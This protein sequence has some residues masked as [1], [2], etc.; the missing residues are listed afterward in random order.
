MGKYNLFLHKKQLYAAVIILIASITGC[1]TTVNKKL[2]HD[3]SISAVTSEGMEVYNGL[4]IKNEYQENGKNADSGSIIS[5]K[6]GMT[7]TIRNGY[8]DGGEIGNIEK[9]DY[10]DS[11]QGKKLNEVVLDRTTMSK[12]QITP[13]FDLF[14]KYRIK[15]G[16]L[17]DV[18]YQMRTWTRKDKFKIAIDHTI[19][20]KFVHSPELNETQIIRPDGN[21]TLPY[22]G[23]VSP[24]GLTVAEFMDKLKKDYANVLQDPEI[25]VTVPEFQRNIKELKADLHT[26]PRGLSRL[27]TVRPDGQA[28]FAMVGHLDVAEKTIPEVNAILNK[29]YDEMIP[30]LHC[31]LFLE[32]HVGSVIYVV[33]EVKNPGAYTIRKP[34]SVVEAVSLAGSH[35]PG[36]KLNSVIVARKHKDNVIATRINLNNVLNMKKD[37]KFFFLQPDDIVYVPRTFVKKAADVMTDIA[38]IFMFRGWGA[39][40]TF[41]YRLH[42]T[43]TTGR[44][45]DDTTTTP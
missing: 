22:L 3:N 45:N 32:K 6:E 40:L 43:N 17:L 13:P 26:A 25:Y 41:Q 29:M 2:K 27:V 34:I 44:R 38:S 24:V 33:G 7:K 19:S 23:E 16:D 12:G 37:S 14:P 10:L 20:V 11:S 15:P 35:I 4:N 31:D 5:K 21:I 30:G 18:L 1:A 9:E 28:T 39:N 42:D 36:A 8:T